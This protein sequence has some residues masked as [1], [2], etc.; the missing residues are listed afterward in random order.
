MKTENFYIGLGLV[1]VSILCLAQFIYTKK[2]FYPERRDQIDGGTI[3][4]LYGGI[5]MLIVG[6]SLMVLSFNTI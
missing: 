2:K 1:I 3:S 4:L 6:I 5:V